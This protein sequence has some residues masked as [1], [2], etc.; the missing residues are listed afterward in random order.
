MVACNYDQSANSDDGSCEFESCTGCVAPAACNFDPTAIYAGQCEWPEQ[1]L[2]CEGNCLADADGDGVC[3][4]DEINGCTDENA[5]NYEPE[6]TEDDG[7]CIDP[8]QGCTNMEACNYDFSAT[9]DDGSCEFE[10]CVV[11][12]S[13]GL[14]L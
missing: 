1:G 8:I 7:S 10:S 6:A 3:N 11:F 13:S 14:Q 5:V 12:V 9:S 4:A 2:D